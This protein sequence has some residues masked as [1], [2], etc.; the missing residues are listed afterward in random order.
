MREGRVGSIVVLLF[1]SILIATTVVPI[2]GQAQETVPPPDEPG[3]YQVG[4]TII[5]NI[6][7]TPGKDLPI[8]II[9]PAKETGRDTSVEESNAPY[10]TLFTS[11]G[12]SQGPASFLQFAERVSSHGF[13]VIVVGSSAFALATERSNDLVTALD[14]VLEQND[15]QSFRLSNLVDVNRLAVSGH[16]TGGAGSV[17]TASK[18]SRFNVCIPMAAA[19]TPRYSEVGPEYAENIQMPILII[20]G[21]DDRGFGDIYQMAHEAYNASNTPKFLIT[22]PNVEHSWM[23]DYNFERYVIPFLKVYLD[24]NDAYVTYL[25]GEHAQQEIDEGKIELFYDIIEGAA[26]FEL[27]NLTVDPSSVEVGGTVSVFVEVSNIGEKSGTHNITLKI[28]DDVEDE[29]AVTLNPD[30]SETVS[31]EVSASQLGTFSVEVDGLSGSYTVIEPEEPTFWER[32][33]GFPY[34]AIVMGLIVGVLVL[35][36]IQQRR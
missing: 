11:T 30:E 1:L 2:K 14:W 3:P 36:L 4:Y 7:K 25:Y 35:W 16:S 27:S 23:S 24:G 10:P 5:F 34:E 18:E 17:I 26:V 32:I 8:Y 28:N 22:V 21:E 31:F 13:A 29:K 20:V 12:Y 19:L 9:Y 15:N 6:S 33:P